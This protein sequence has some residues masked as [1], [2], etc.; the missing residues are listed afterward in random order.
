MTSGWTLTDPLCPVSFFVLTQV[1]LLVLNVYV[2]EE[3]TV[4]LRAAV[5]IC[6]VLAEEAVRSGDD[7]ARRDQSSGAEV[8]L[9]HVNGCH[10]GVGARQRRGA[11]QNP[12]HGHRQP[13]LMLFPAYRFSGWLGG[14]GVCRGGRDF[15]YVHSGRRRCVRTSRVGEI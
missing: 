13:L 12:A 1:C 10:P 4:T 5:C 2:G 8:W 3:E 7:P 15:K 14:G 11:A 9:S 6:D